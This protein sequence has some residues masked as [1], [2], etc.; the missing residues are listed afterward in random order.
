MANKPWKYDW[1]FI[2]NI[3]YQIIELLNIYFTGTESRRGLD[4][5]NNLDLKYV[6]SVSLKYKNSRF[7][8]LKFFLLLSIT[9]LDYLKI[10]KLNPKIILYEHAGDFNPII[11]VLLYNF[12][13][14]CI[15]YVDCHTCVYIDNNYNLVR[16]FF[17]T[18]S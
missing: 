14:K 1:N 9:F 8:I 6:K 13:H 12:F 17:N 15:L 18:P 16:E 7:I 5:S 3:S 11:P 10:K 2:S 4:I